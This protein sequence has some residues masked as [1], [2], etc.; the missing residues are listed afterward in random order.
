MSQV[1]HRAPG[2]EEASARSA[3]VVEAEHLQRR[4]GGRLILAD[5][6]FSVAAG[7][8]FGIAGSNGSGKSVLLRL[9]ASLDRPTGGAA[10]ILGHDNP[11][12]VTTADLLAAADTPAALVRIAG[13]VACGLAESGMYW[14]ASSPPAR[15]YLALLTGSG[16]TPDDWT[17]D[18][19]ARNAAPVA[20]GSEDIGAGDDCTRPTRPTRPTTPRPTTTR[21]ASR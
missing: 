4:F 7:E 11:R 6:T 14:S 17:A 10:T 1:L 12:E 9:L 5:V 2:T 3:P 15:D 13:A 16:W 19:L 20:D 18:V 21:T 8:A